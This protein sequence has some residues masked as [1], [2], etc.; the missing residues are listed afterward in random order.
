MTIKPLANIWSFYTFPYILE[1][2]KEQPESALFQGLSGSSDAFLISNLYKQI[3]CPLI[4]FVENNKKAETLVEE[5]RSLIDLDSVLFF[6]S[7]DAV[8]YNFKSP[9]GPTTE[10]RFKV[11]NALLDGKKNIVITPSATLLQKIPSQRD[12]FKKIIH[13]HCNDEISLNELSDWLIDIGFHRENQISDIGMFSIR[14]GIVDIYPFLSDY[15]FRLEFWGNTIDSIR[16]FDIFTQKSLDQCPKITIFPLKEFN[17]NASQI[18]NSLQSIRDSCGSANDSLIGYNKLEHQ[19]KN[20]DLEG[21]EWF[22]H[23][24]NQKCVSILDYISPNSILVWNDILPQQHRFTE[25]R[26]NYE[27][28]KDRAPSIFS[29]LLSSPE[30]LLFT[31][32]YLNE[33]LHC[34]KT[35]YI[36]TTDIDG[37]VPVYQ[38]STSD[39]PQLP[40]EIN[41]ISENLNFYLSRS[42]IC[43]LVCSNLGHAERIIELIDDL[44]SS[45]Q[46]FIG[47]ITHGYIDKQNKIVF[48][49]ESQILHQPKSFISYRKKSKSLPISNFDALSPDDFIVHEDHGIARFLG[50][51]HITAG[52][53]KQDCMVLLY[54]GG[55]KIY[56]PIYDFFKVQKYIGKDSNPPQLSKIGSSSWEKL[57]EKTRESIQTMASELI[58]LYAQRQ[59]LDGIQFNSDTI[60]QKEFEDSFVYD[61]TEDQLRAIKEI[62]NDMESKKPMDRLICGDVGFGKTEVAM[63]AAFKAVMSGYQ[64]AILVPTTILASQHYTTFSDRMR[65]FPVKITVLS[66]FVKMY[67]IRKRLLEIQNGK[68]DII[69]GTHRILS[70]DVSFKNLGLLIID[71]EQRFGVQHK[72]KIQQFRYK[73]DVLSLTATPI[74]RTLQLSLIGARDL[75]II[76]TPP[77][78]R[79]PIETFVTPYHDEELKTAIE[80]ELDRG[81]QVYY[82]NNRIN[83][84]EI[85]KDSIERLVPKAKVIIAH[86]QMNEELL[87]TIMKD[88]IAGRYDVLLSTVI[89]ENGLDIPNVNTIIVNRADT[90][91]LSQL[92]QL[93]G[94]VGRS[95]EQAYSFFFTPPFKEL[96]DISLKRLKALE[97]YTE[98]GS[99]FQIAMRDLEIRGAGNIL[100]TKQHGFI[101]AIGF[102]LYCRILQEA[103]D[104][105]KGITTNLKTPEIKIEIP[106][107]A[108][109]PIEYINDGQN[110]IAIYQE[111]SSFTDLDAII[112]FEQTLLD[113]FGPFPNTVASLL[114]IIKIKIIASSIQINHLI[115]SQ[116]SPA[117][118]YFTGNEEQI[119]KNIA[120][121]FSFEKYQYQLSNTIPL[122]LKISL[123]SNSILEQSIEL[124][125]LLKSISIKLKI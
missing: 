21:A 54:A 20:G 9:F 124:F 56:V 72:E 36:E 15:P 83:S 86:G 2:C 39:Q 22:L 70:Q 113:R 26:N 84:L 57:K 30:H 108:Y 7:R 66:R 77:Q 46:I 102:E 98:L 93:R 35:I 44:S 27:R 4:V 90:F 17:F 109:I 71:E 117:L 14:G 65:D 104:E 8:P 37:T 67:D 120:L 25:T 12:L 45:L 112:N 69:I 92:Y 121:F 82:V 41:A 59:Y 58:E 6:P 100:G 78:N 40:K 115:I 42:Y 94:R 76:N 33:I 89:I 13:L 111:L 48:Y 1:Y 96:T 91:G 122:N 103:L 101:E 5:C 62:K 99:G 123:L 3:D 97:Q 73:I 34:F 43:V 28:H 55:T 23:W 60:W 19:W 105:K 107:E 95:S 119:K 110:R 81:G 32:N 51:E 125:E 85:I 53:I 80:N 64:V 24:F 61:E 50:I 106:L 63:R 87:E 18:N 75:S 49:S 68:I 52:E 88:F 74:P 31:D 116:N 114:I 11:L 79:L 118:L 29:T 16:K 47:F 10:A 38:L